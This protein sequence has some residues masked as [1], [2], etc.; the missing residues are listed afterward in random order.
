MPPSSRI[1]IYQANRKM[2]DAEVKDIKK[3]AV[4][5]VDD[6]TAHQ[7]SLHASFEIFYN[8]FLVLAVDESHN[9]ASGCSV[10]KSV[11]FIREI[12][13]RFNVS[14]LDRFNIAFRYGESVEVKSLKDFQKMM[15]EDNLP[16][17]TPVF[18]NLIYRKSDL[19]KKWEVPLR[20]SWLA[21]KL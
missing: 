2:S 19:E 17:S 14:L 6:W 4:D 21:E 11:Y 9:D 1:W 8:V 7:Q 5:F 15:K 20:D 18:N 3:Q 10:D 13:N 16:E 12:E